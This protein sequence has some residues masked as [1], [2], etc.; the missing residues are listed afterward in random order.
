[1]KIE[2]II[3]AEDA[4]KK[5][6]DILKNKLYIST[7]L[8]NDLKNT[9]SIFV[10]K[11]IYLV[12]DIVK[13]K[14]RV[15][16]DFENMDNMLNENK[17]LFHNKFKMIDKSL[18]IIYEDD[19]LLIVNKPANM[20]VHP[21]SDNYENTLSNIVSNYL[22]KQGIY[23]IH[24][25]TRLDKNTTGLCIFAKHKYIQELFIRKKDI[26]NLQ[27]EYICIVDGIIED[28]HFIIEKNIA[29]KE[30]TIILR[31]VNEKGDYAKTECFV[32]DRNIDKN[33]TILRILLHTGRTHQIRVHLASI[34]HVLL[35]DELYGIEYNMSDICK[36]ID[37]QALHCN[38]LSFNH[39]IT[40][41]YIELNGIMPDDINNLINEKN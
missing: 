1:M 4:G 34:G 9:R 32:I 35:G 6:K 7:I 17:A 16:I 12:N 13:E 28:N 26:I 5:L 23:T 40:N 27:K 37:R 18:D 24:I 22:Y 21:S 14:D 19:Y 31:E 38:K 8:L 39:P 29:R 30:G 41:K 33:Y 25:V 10:N 15:L 11:N 36:Y 2:Y 20:P 3:T